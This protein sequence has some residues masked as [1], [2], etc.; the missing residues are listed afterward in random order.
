MAV[1]FCEEKNFAFTYIDIFATGMTVVDL[2]KKVDQLEKDTL[3][4]AKKVWSLENRNKELSD[5]YKDYL[6]DMIKNNQD[7]SSS[8]LLKHLQALVITSYSIHYTKLY[9][10]VDYSNRVSGHVLFVRDITSP[11][12][13]EKK[14]DELRNNFV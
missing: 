11:H 3:R 1:K 5:Q 6:D 2:Q 13:V 9:E 14:Y 10:S 8:E 12:S 4:L 7:K